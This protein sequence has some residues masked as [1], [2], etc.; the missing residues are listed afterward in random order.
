MTRGKGS[1]TPK[2]RNLA[3]LGVG[4]ALGY[5]YKAHRAAED[6]KLRAGEQVQRTQA[7]IRGSLGRAFGLKPAPASSTPPAPASPAS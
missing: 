2:S 5:L 1:M 6:G 4:L 3:A 7:D